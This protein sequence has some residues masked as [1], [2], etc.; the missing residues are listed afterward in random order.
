MAVVKANAYGHG[1]FEVSQA[2][3]KAGIARLCVARLEEALALR[4][5]GIHAP[6][7]VLGYTSPLDVPKAVRRN[8]SLALFNAELAPQ[9]Q[10]AASTTDG[11]LNVHIKVDTGMGRLGIFPENAVEFIA[12]V[13][14]M[15]HINI[16]GLFTH[17]ASADEPQK[18]TTD[19]QI[20]RFNRVVTE[21]EKLGIRPAIVH[22]GNSAGYAVLFPGLVR[23]CTAGKCHLRSQ[24]FTGSPAAD[25]FRAGAGLEDTP[26]LGQDTAAGFGHQLQSPLRDPG[27]REDRGLGRRLC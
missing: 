20:V 12:Q 19:E 5:A 18:S 9:Y 4:D 22:A 11:K 8:I 3:E 24:P 23:C 2:A 15:D 27:I 25:R 21:V 13:A 10:E 14:H 16:E 7:L 26:D 6:I 1:L 17:F